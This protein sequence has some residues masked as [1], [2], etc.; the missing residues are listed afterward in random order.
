MLGTATRTRKSG[1]CTIENYAVGGN[2]GKMSSSIVPSGVRTSESRPGF[3]SGL[4]GW[5]LVY[6]IGLATQALHGLGL[7]LGAIVIFADP[8]RA[9]LTSLEPIGPLLFYV[10]TNIILAGYTAVLLSLMVRRRRAA[11]VNGVVLNSSLCCC[12][13]CGVC[14]RKITGG[15]HCRLSSGIGG[16]RVHSA[17]EE[18]SRYLHLFSGRDAA[19]DF[20]NSPLSITEIPQATEAMEG[21]SGA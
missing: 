5:L 6:M 12:S 10:I 14:S 11:I 21:L 7:T 16:P 4:R 2:H 19:A 20:R 8:G 15:H 13:R 1:A 3:P 18:G 17:L 9:G